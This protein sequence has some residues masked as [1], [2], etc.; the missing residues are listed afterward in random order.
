MRNFTITINIDREELVNVLADARVQAGR[1]S[2]VSRERTLAIQNNSKEMKAL[3]DIL[4]AFQNNLI[5][6]KRAETAQKEPIAE[7][8]N[9]PLR[10]AKEKS[11]YDKEAIIK[12]LQGMY[13]F[14][15]LRSP[16]RGYAD[17]STVWSNFKNN[18][19]PV[20]MYPDVF[21]EICKFLGFDIVSLKDGNTKRPYILLGEKPKEAKEAIKEAVIDYIKKNY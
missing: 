4:V 6:P 2:E 21:T 8:L 5:Q 18:G 13:F 20:E 9:L 12:R 1:K 14:K 7:Q 3:R 16:F 19:A 15:D 17:I 10:D 11:T